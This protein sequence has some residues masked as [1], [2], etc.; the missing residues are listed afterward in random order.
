MGCYVKPPAMTK[1]G[2]LE[3]HGLPV[4]RPIVFS[5]VPADCLLV[6]LMDNGPFTAA[7]VA[8]D[9]REFV[10][11]NDDPTDTRPKQWYIVTKD[12]LRT[13]SPLDDYA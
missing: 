10:A 9:E 1:E 6:C 12:D 2:W 7:G 8:F 5:D 11:F 3:Q 13:V 4:S